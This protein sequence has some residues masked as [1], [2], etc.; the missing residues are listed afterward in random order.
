MQ[1]K[2]IILGVLAVIAITCVQ[3]SDASPVLTVDTVNSTCISEKVIP[4]N[5]SLKIRV[6]KTNL[7]TIKGLSFAVTAINGVPIKIGEKTSLWNLAGEDQMEKIYLP[8]SQRLG[9]F[10]GNYKTGTKWSKEGF[11]PNWEALSCTQHGD[12][13]E[14]VFVEPKDA[15]IDQKESVTLEVKFKAPEF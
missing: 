6:S 13:F 9:I 1:N 2:T 3:R 4:T 11:S 12:Y 5:T 15:P 7:P 14:C 10:V 8:K